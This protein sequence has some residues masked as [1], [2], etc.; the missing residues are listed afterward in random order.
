MRICLLVALAE[1]AIGFAVPST[2]Q[3]QNTVDPEVRQ[4]IEAV[5][6]KFGDAHNK[7]DAAA[8]AALYTQDVSPEF[9]L[10]KT[11]A[12]DFLVDAV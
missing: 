6:M 1:L 8:I 11:E 4:Q 7:D 9:Y 10:R 2:A 5:Y 3:K 12:L